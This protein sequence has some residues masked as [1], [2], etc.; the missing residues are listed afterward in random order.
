MVTSQL[1]MRSKKRSSLAAFSR[2]TASMAGEGSMFRKLICKGICIFF[3]FS[4]L[5]PVSSALSASLDLVDHVVHT[6]NIPGIPFGGI[7][8]RRRWDPAGQAHGAPAHANTNLRGVEE[9]VLVERDPD[10][11]LDLNWCVVLRRID[12]DAVDHVAHAWHPPGEHAGKTLR[13]EARQA[14]VERDDAALNLDSDVVGGAGQSGAHE[15]RFTLLTLLDGELLEGRF[16]VIGFA[17]MIEDAVVA[18][19]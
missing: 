13:R 12:S 6:Q 8:R 18:H 11:L 5:K 4:I 3:S 14:A 16:L 9:R 2:T 17:Q 19:G 10:R 15:L 1:T 7:A